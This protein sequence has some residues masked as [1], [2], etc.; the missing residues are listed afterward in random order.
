[1][2][3][4]ALISG[5]YGQDA[6]YLKDELLNDN[7]K[8]IGLTRKIKK[9]QK[10][11]EKIILI[12]TNYSENSLKKIFQENNIDVVFHLCGQSKV[13][14]SWVHIN[15]T[16]NSQ[17]LIT[18]NFL[19]VIHKFSNK[20]KFINSSSSEIFKPENNKLINEDSSFYPINPYGV[21]QLFSFNLCKI[22]REKYNLFISSVILFPHESPI[23]NELFVVKK[24]ISSLIRI[25]NGSKEKLVLGNIDVV[26]DFG[27]APEYMNA[28]ILVSK[29]NTPD[30]FCI[31]TSK[32][33]SIREILLYVLN[34][35]NLNIDESVNF[36]A[37]L[38][39]YFEYES[40]IGDYSKIKNKLGW[41]PKYFGNKLIKKLIQDE[42]IKNKSEGS[43]FE[44]KG[45]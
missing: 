5:I 10:L 34:H 18:L 43:N 17:G 45:P 9:N 30:D 3:K 22:F 28:M 8:I 25:S 40:I 38:T 1:M 32:G 16:I 26:R 29:A 11:H 19:N 42:I 15:E 20:T 31:C 37:K 35:F 2:V 39:R 14:L 36:D 24:I 4:T 23:R 6:H 33:M 13:G 12:Q 7:Y 21:A 27:Y 41:S 44:V